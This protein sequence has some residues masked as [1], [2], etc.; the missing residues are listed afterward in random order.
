MLT[1]LAVDDVLVEPVDLFVPFADDEELPVVAAFSGSAVTAD[2]SNAI[3]S[4]S[5]AQPVAA[6][7]PVSVTK[8]TATRIGDEDMVRFSRQEVS[9][10]PGRQGR[11]PTKAAFPQRRPSG[12]NEVA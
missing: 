7:I 8:N 10:R 3:A 6:G 5:G 4:A 9:G 11:T 2:R 1:C 12:N